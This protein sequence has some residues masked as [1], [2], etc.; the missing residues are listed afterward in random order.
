MKVNRDYRTIQP[1]R[2][3]DNL[4]IDYKPYYEIVKGVYKFFDKDI[5]LKAMYNYGIMCQCERVIINNKVTYC[6]NGIPITQRQKDYLKKRA[7]F[8]SK[9]EDLYYRSSQ[10]NCRKQNEIN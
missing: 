6:Y 5:K 10:C 9:N 7:E 1:F 8:L 2:F 3:K 4:N